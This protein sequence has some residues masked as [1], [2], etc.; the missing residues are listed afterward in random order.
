MMRVLKTERDEELA[1]EKRR[2]GIGVGVDVVDS[3]LS[4]YC[5]MRSNIVVECGI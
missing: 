4:L 1:V 5:A 3:I 2:E